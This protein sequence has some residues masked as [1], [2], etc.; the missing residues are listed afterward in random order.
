MHCKTFQ[1]IKRSLQWQGDLFSQKFAENIFVT[2]GV[3][4]GGGGGGGA[5]VVWPPGFSHSVKLPK[6]QK[7]FHFQ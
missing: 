1:F 6:F 3:G 4:K 2:M 7:F 5:G